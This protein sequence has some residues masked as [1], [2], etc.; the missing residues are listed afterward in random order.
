MNILIIEDDPT[1]LKLLI[2]VLDHSGHHA[3]GKATAELALAEIKA[4]KPE[5]ILLDLK[6]PDLPGLELARR[7]KAD[8]D[9]Q[10]IPIVAVTALRDQFSR[11]DALAAGCDAYIV[12]PVDT[13]TLSAQIE[14]AAVL[15]NASGKK[16]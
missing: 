11:G 5:M 15:Q 9:T 14:S 10:S 16:T 12:K 7:L 8:P 4:R 1:D 13:R 2:A 3:I 6:L